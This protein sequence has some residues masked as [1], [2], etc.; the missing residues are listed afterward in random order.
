MK[1]M[2]LISVAVLCLYAAA[3]AFATTPGLGPSYWTSAMV[4]EVSF[5]SNPH[6]QLWEK[7]LKNCPPKTEGDYRRALQRLNQG[8]EPEPCP[9]GVG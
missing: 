1:R 6:K 2:A 7:W 5:T 8:Q 3:P 4:A 9:A